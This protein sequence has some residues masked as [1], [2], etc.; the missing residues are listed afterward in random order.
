MEKYEG[1]LEG[2]W[3]QGWEGRIEYSL[4]IE[5]IGHPFF[6]QS[7][8]RLT[9][10]N[11]D[12]SVLWSDV[13]HFVARGARDSHNMPNG[14][15]ADTKQANVP[16]AQWIEWFWRKPPLK[17]TY[18]VIADKTLPAK[19]EHAE[20][21]IH[22][23]VL[24]MLLL[25]YAF[26]MHWFFPVPLTTLPQPVKALGVGLVF[27]GLAFAFLA[28]R[29]FTRA[30]TTLNP[31]G[32][33][34]TLVTS[35]VYRFSRNPIYVGFVCALIGIPLAL[36]T[37]WGAMFSPMLVWGLNTLVI[38]YEESHLEKRFGDEYARY[39]SRVRRWL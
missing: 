31:H 37:L 30:H 3:E 20:V 17:A 4:F 29:E 27:A 14:I 9:I 23:P 15:W 26:A 28:V 39:R 1:H 10:F 11:E 2:Y 32:S 38:R 19:K 34:A 8:D 33:A 24:T 5:G 22:P 21:K 18:E 25:A 36:G 12:G 35:G 16:Y 7:G 13:L 6:L